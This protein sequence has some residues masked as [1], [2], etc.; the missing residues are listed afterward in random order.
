MSA[1]TLRQILLAAGKDMRLEAADKRNLKALAKAFGE[2]DQARIAPRLTDLERRKGGRPSAELAK[3]AASLAR[4]QTLLGASLPR[5]V[6]A[7]LQLITETAKASPTETVLQFVESLRVALRPSKSSRRTR[8]KPLNTDFVA[9]YVRRLGEAL[10]DPE[11]FATA[12]A[13]LEAD[14]GVRN[15]ELVAIAAEFYGAVPAGSSRK[16]CLDL[17]RMRHRA[18]MNSRAKARA[19]SGKSAA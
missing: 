16:D 7:E 11:K 18:L 19:Q 8:G 6:R 3:L 1:M 17:I 4:C 15:A 9:L 13:E 5:G 2:S 10:R 12:V 14:R